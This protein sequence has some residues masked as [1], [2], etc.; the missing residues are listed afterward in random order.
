[1]APQEL[2]VDVDGRVVAAY[3]VGADAGPLV[4][5]HHGSPSS[6]LEVTWHHD[7]SRRR[8]VRVVGM[9]RPGYGA[10]DPMSFTFAS[11]ASDACAVADALGATQFAVVGQSSGCGHAF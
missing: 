8:G 4:L 10:S 5:Y 11:V 7:V 3:A 6:R 9:D 1:M 2:R